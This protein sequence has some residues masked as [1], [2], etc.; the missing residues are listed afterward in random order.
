MNSIP[1]IASLGLCLGLPSFR[2]STP[3]P[4]TKMDP[5]AEENCVKAC[6]E[7]RRACREYLIHGGRPA[8]DKTCLTRIETCRACVAIME[9]D[10]PLGKEM[11]RVC[12]EACKQSAAECSKSAD[13][14]HTKKCVEAC[15]QCENACRALAMWTEGNVG[16]GS[17]GRQLPSESA[18]LCSQRLRS[19]P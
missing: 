9:P 1:L 4:E 8:C 11:D 14:P 13:T 16:G 6:N 10:S 3:A 18:M 2:A 17:L 7:C 5:V 12:A 15:K 19:T